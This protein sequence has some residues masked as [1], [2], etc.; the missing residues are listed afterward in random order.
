MKILMITLLSF[1]KLSFALISPYHQEAKE[2]NAIL[3]ATEFHQMIGSNELVDRLE[4][5][6][7]GYLI[8]TTS[9]LIRVE[10]IYVANPIPGPTK[11]TLVFNKTNL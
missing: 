9:A 11:F 6:D 2:I 3:G 4:K 10:V 8:Q 5:V 1:A 7:G